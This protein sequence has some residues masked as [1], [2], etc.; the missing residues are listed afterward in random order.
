MSSPPASF[1]S[2]LQHWKMMDSKASPCVAKAGSST[3]RA[4]RAQPSTGVAAGDSG[5][6][7]GEDIQWPTLRSVTANV[8]V[9]GSADHPAKARPACSAP[10]GI[11]QNPRTRSNGSPAPSTP[12]PEGDARE[13]YPRCPNISREASPDSEIDGYDD[14]PQVEHEG[15]DQATGASCSAHSSLPRVAT[16]EQAKEVRAWTPAQDSPLPAPVG[17]SNVPESVVTG[18]L[19]SWTPAGQHRIDLDVASSPR[20]NPTSVEA[21]FFNR[22]PVQESGSTPPL[23]PPFRSPPAIPERSLLLKSAPAPALGQVPETAPP[24]EGGPRNQVWSPNGSSIFPMRYRVADEVRGPI[25]FHHSTAIGDTGAVTQSVTSEPHSMLALAFHRH[26]QVDVSSC[27]CSKGFAIRPEA[28]LV[29]QLEPWEDDQKTTALISFV[30]EE[31]TPPHSTADVAR[32]LVSLVYGRTSELKS[33][34]GAFCTCDHAAMVIGQ[35]RSG[36][37]VRV[38]LMTPLREIGKKSLAFSSDMSSDADLFTEVSTKAFSDT[39]SS[40]AGRS[41]SVQSVRSEAK[42]VAAMPFQ[43][44]TQAPS[45]VGQASSPIHRLGASQASVLVQNSWQE[46]VQDLKV[47][48]AALKR[49]VDFA[50]SSPQM[51]DSVPC[52]TAATPLKARGSPNETSGFDAH[53]V[54]R[55]IL[56]APDELPKSNANDDADEFRTAWARLADR[57]AHT[58]SD[59]NGP[60]KNKLGAASNDCK[61]SCHEQAQH[62]DKSNGDTDEDRGEEENGPS[63]AGSISI[64]RVLTVSRSA[65]S[66]PN[67]QSPSGSQRGI[68]ETFRADRELASLQRE[69]LLQNIEAPSSADMAARPPL[70]SSSSMALQSPTQTILSTSHELSQ[71]LREL[72]SRHPDV[73]P[74]RQLVHAVDRYTSVPNEVRA[75]ESLQAEKV[76]RY[77]QYPVQKDCALAIARSGTANAFIG[78]APGGDFALYSSRY[79]PLTPPPSDNYGRARLLTA[80]AAN[81]FL[82]TTQVSRMAKIEWGSSLFA[83]KINTGIDSHKE[84]MELT[85]QNAAMPGKVSGGGRGE[86]R[87]PRDAMQR[88]LQSS[89]LQRA[90]LRQL[91][92]ELCGG[93]RLASSSL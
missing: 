75:D 83:D 38:Y 54:N 34:G 87:G 63:S 85:V 7:S 90:R 9:S 74:E 30:Q 72:A 35:G 31:L 53:V 84:N 82:H 6:R 45:P 56:P 14:A 46:K 36:R 80:Q 25:K 1:S 11:S 62:V 65:K 24:K 89:A 8:R 29:E 37:K 68:D 57:Q 42:S 48:M 73:T 81:R 58:S 78:A 66:T 17:A 3:P 23:V 76:Q 93:S 61:L 77:R 18:S 70:I 13:I 16:P 64:P 49:E 50:I 51:R 28:V 59:A 47:E 67:E 43:V 52:A 5:E 4:C 2:K 27:L 55:E 92:Q 71:T 21:T 41:A 60:G 15:R 19:T 12:G 32:L 91:Q 39:S 10:A 88:A 69:E 22:S 79:A 33:H 20:K 40:S 86:A 26:V 44:S